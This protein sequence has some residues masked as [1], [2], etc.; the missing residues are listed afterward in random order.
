MLHLVQCEWGSM[1]VQFVFWCSVECLNRILNNLINVLEVPLPELL[2][3]ERRAEDTQASRDCV[4]IA[5]DAKYKV[6]N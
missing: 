1:N 2:V 3:F 4:D 5:P 6:T